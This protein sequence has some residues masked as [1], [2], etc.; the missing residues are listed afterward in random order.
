M[1]PT[2]TP[3]ELA[4]DA[5][6]RARKQARKDGVVLG[7]VAA[8]LPEHHSEEHFRQQHEDANAPQTPE[9]V[10]GVDDDL[11]ALRK[12]ELVE[13]AHRRGLPV[14]GTKADL[15]ERLRA[16]AEGQEAV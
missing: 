6:R 12:D 15:L 11:D 4:A 2:S 8:G 9:D 10:L 7:G 14:G 1:S 5:A 13:L 3:A 16:W